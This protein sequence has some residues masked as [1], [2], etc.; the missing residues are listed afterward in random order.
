MHLLLS[1]QYFSKYA[2]WYDSTVFQAVS[3]KRREPADQ[4]K[5]RWVFSQWGRAWLRKEKR[6]SSAGGHKVCLW[7]PVFLKKI[8]ANFSSPNL[9]LSVSNLCSFTIASSQFSYSPVHMRMSYRSHYS[10]QV[11]VHTHV[12]CWILWLCWR[13]PLQCLSFL[14]F[15]SGLKVLGLIQ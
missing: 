10:A 6:R 2:G 8:F 15:L 4:Q 5:R 11:T 13:G 9:R 14:L 7:L 3:W 1:N 12:L